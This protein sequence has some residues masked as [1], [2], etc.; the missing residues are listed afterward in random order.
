MKSFFKKNILLAIFLDV[1]AFLSLYLI[2][3]TAHRLLNYDP[4]THINIKNPIYDYF[5]DF[6]LLFISQIT[7][8]Q[9]INSKLL[10]DKSEIKVAHLV[11]LVLT[12]A[13][14]FI[15][16]IP[17]YIQKA[18]CHKIF[19]SPILRNTDAV[20]QCSTFMANFGTGQAILYF[21]VLPA[22]FLFTSI[23]LLLNLFLMS[24]SAVKVKENNYYLKLLWRVI[25]IL[26]IL[27]YPFYVI[28]RIPFFLN[29][30]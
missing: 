22:I 11:F 7:L 29:N 13:F 19:L 16:S 10:K 2:F 12:I 20:N 4:Q 27:A 8:I 5:T 9:V 30:T 21:I 23:S 24:F 6:F 28:L 14:F 1:F 3:S 17:A 25:I 15:S 18:Q 26:L